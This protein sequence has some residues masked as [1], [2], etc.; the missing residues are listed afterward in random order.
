M[1]NPFEAKAEHKAM[2]ILKNYD[3]CLVTPLTCTDY[4]FGDVEEGE[5]VRCTDIDTIRDMYNDN[6]DVMIQTPDGCNF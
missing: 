4:E 6:Y 5:P 3:Y 2:N 1:T